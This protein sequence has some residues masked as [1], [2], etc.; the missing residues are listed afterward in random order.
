MNRYGGY[1]DLR[2]Y[3]DSYALAKDVFGSARSFPPKN[4]T[5][6]TDQ[7]VRSSRS[8]PANIAEGWENDDMKDVRQQ[9]G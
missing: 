4:A 5:S 8:V 7:I 3:Q 1:K 9:D 6:L 2:V